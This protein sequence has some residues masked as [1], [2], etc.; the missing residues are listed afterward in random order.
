MANTRSQQTTLV[1]NNLADNTSEQITPQKHRQVETESITASAFVDDTNTFTGAN[2]FTQ[3]VTVQDGEI[4][5]PT[6]SIGLT[7]NIGSAGAGNFGG[8]NCVQI[9]INAGLNNIGGV[10]NQIGENAGAANTGGSNNQFGLFAGNQNAAQGCNQLGQNAGYENGG[11]YCNQ[12]GLNAGVRNTGANCNQLGQSAG[13]EN[14]GDYCNQLGLNAG[15]RNTGNNVNAFGPNAGRDNT[16]DGGVFIGPSAGFDTAGYT[17]VDAVFAIAN[18][19]IPE[20]ADKNAADAAITVS[21]GYP[22]GSTYIYRNNQHGWIG[23][24]T[25]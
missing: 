15:V 21:N 16:K 17:G 24:V 20:F 3:P 19:S 7:I 9:G 18:A 14:G 6:P 4:H 12:L 10:C 22:A 5:M 8:D 11:D 23:F 13:Y 2:E 25:L 1:N